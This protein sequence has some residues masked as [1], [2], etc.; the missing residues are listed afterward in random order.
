MKIIATKFRLYWPLIKSLQTS[1]LLMTGMAGY[2]K[3]ACHRPLE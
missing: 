1:L 2:F 3:R